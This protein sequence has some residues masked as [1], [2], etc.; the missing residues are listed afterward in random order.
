VTGEF[1]G[2]AYS[3]LKLPS[4]SGSGT[5]TLA[6]WAYVA[7]MPNTPDGRPFSAGFDPHTITAYTSPNT[8][9]SYAV[10]VDYE[11]QPSP[12][13]AVIDLS[14][15]LSQP[16]AAGTHNVVGNASACTRYVVIP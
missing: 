5:P 7:T 8:G 15:V 6:D 11:S 13:L 12:Y 4:T 2:Q 3:A 9:L 10:I 16:R 1:G 14:C